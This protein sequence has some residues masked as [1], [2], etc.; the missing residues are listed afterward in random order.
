M[1]MTTNKMV[2]MGGFG[3]GVNVAGWGSVGT[4]IGVSVGR[5]GG[6]D[7]SGATGSV[8]GG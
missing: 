8:M 6:A 5:V 4:S 2:T 3:P 7:K 1:A